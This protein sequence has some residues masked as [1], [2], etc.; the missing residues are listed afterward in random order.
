MPFY[1]TKI[2]GEMYRL[3][4]DH[5]NALKKDKI[6][7]WNKADIWLKI[8]KLLMQLASNPFENFLNIKKLQPKTSNTFR[9]KANEYRIIYSID[10]GNKIILIHRI[11]LRKEVYK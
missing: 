7:L 3:F 1:L 4:Y 11:W 9:L 5:S 2:F 10:T 6:A 8:Q